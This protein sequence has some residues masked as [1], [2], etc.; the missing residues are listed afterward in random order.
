MGRRGLSVPCAALEALP[1][2]PRSVNHVPRRPPPG[3]AGRYKM[4]RDWVPLIEPWR[5]RDL[6]ESGQALR[7]L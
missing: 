5:P 7:P 3:E 4:G 6:V 1:S 2:R